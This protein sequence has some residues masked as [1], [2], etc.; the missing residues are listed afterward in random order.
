MIM[1]KL[2]WVALPVA[3]FV[4]AASG[5]WTVAGQERSDTPPLAITAFGGKAVDFK[6]PRTPWGDPDLQGVWSSDDMENVA[7]G[8]RRP[9]RAWRPGPDWP[10]AALPGRRGV[11]GA[12]GAGQARRHPAG[13]QRREFLP[14][15]L[16]AARLSPDA[17]DCRS[18][19]WPPSRDQARGARAAH[20][21]RHVRSRPAGFVARLLALRTLHHARHCRIDSSRHLRQRQ[22]DCASSRRGGALVRDAARHAH[23]L[24]GWATAH[25][26][27]HP[28]V[29]G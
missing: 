2:G 29:P 21:A 11:P 22:P 25:Q 9:R 7:D 12:P 1:R 27:A 26:S 8:R 10:A 20:A 3:V 19:G 4:L 13:Y 18:A 6:A 5:G 23:L 14:L 15:R 28:R 16:R 17:A 24:H